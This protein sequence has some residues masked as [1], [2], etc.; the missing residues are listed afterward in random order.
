MN[1][2]SLKS[3]LQH[4][5]QK[6]SQASSNHPTNISLESTALTNPQTETQN[7]MAQESSASTFG[8]PTTPK[9]TPFLTPNPLS[10]L[11]SQEDIRSGLSSLSS[12]LLNNDDCRPLITNAIPVSFN[13]PN[14]VNLIV[15]RMTTGLNCWFCYKF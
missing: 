11:G 8:V 13:S 15:N 3:K 1:I 5:Y 14:S 12:G 6:Y 4:Q 9:T 7:E 10:P 2:Y